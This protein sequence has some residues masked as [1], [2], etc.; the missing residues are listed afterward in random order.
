MAEIQVNLQQTAN[1]EMFFQVFAG[2]FVSQDERSL[3]DLDLC[4]Q[5]FPQFTIER[6]LEF[7]ARM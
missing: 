4:S 1:V 2:D 7:L 6:L 3:Q 5:L